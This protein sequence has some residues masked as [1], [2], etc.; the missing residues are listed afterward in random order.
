VQHNQLTRSTN[1]YDHPDA[2]A[3]TGQATSVYNCYGRQENDHRNMGVGNM[4]VGNMGVGNMGVGNMGMA[5]RMSEMVIVNDENDLM[6]TKQRRKIGE[7]EE[8]TDFN[9]Y[10][11]SFDI[12]VS[13]GV[14]GRTP[15]FNRNDRRR[16]SRQENQCKN[17]RWNDQNEK[18]PALQHAAPIVQAN[19]LNVYVDSMGPGPDGI[20]RANGINIS[21]AAAFQRCSKC[22]G[23][24]H[25][26]TTCPN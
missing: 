18:M 15:K 9:D 24:G 7:R 26:K 4:G 13:P 10:S 3:V 11:Q 14:M 12:A 16:R 23:A 2:A 5:S 20:L 1:T 25:K 19:I 8:I 6:Q 17:I 22:L 21:P